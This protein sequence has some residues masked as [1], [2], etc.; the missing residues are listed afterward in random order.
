ML[1]LEFTRGTS[2]GTNG[3]NKLR[4]Q[5]FHTRRSEITKE[6]FS[7]NMYSGRKIDLVRIFSAFL[8]NDYGL[9]D[10]FIEIVHGKTGEDFLLNKL[11]LFCVEMLEPDGIFQITKRSFDDQSAAFIGTSS[12]LKKSVNV[13]VTNDI[14]EGIEMEKII[15]FLTL[16]SREIGFRIF[17]ICCGK[18]I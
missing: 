17:G 3:R 16:R 15:R 12:L 8:L 7:A 5:G 14:I 11:R 18:E 1:I 6:E 10:Q 2:T 4:E 13:N 9:G